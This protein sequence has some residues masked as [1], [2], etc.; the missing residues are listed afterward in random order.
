MTDEQIAATARLRDQMIAII[1]AEQ[2]PAVAANK[3]RALAAADPKL[4]SMPPAVIDAQ[5]M[6]MNTDW[7]RFFFNYD[8]APMLRRVRQPVL[9]LIGSKELQVPAD[10]NLP[11]IRAALAGNPNAEIDE[12]PG[13]N[14]LFQTAKTGAISEYGENEETIAP[15]ALDKMTGWIAQHVGPPAH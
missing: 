2:D 11:A 5:I 8:P 6:T 12:M 13:L 14:H 3:I 1:R 10:Q 9:A 15:V 4:K 7:F